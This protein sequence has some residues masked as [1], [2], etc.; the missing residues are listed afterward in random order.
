M[1]ATSRI[2]SRPLHSLRHGAA[3]G[4]MRDGG[5]VCLGEEGCLTGVGDPKVV[6]VLTT[7][8]RYS[9]EVHGHSF[10]FVGGVYTTFFS[11]MSLVPILFTT[12]GVLTTLWSNIV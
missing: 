11:N 8:R 6:G 2:H 7:R 1:R 3:G 5:C 4:C 10:N 9:R 12:P